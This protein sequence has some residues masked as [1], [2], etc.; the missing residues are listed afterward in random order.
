M[1]ALGQIVQRTASITP[2]IGRKSRRLLT[3]YDKLIQNVQ[4]RRSNDFN[5]NLS[6]TEKILYGHG[7]D[8]NSHPY[9][10]TPTESS[11]FGSTTSK[12]DKAV[13]KFP[14]SCDN[15]LGTLSSAV[16]EKSVFPGGLLLA[17]DAYSHINGDFSMLS[18]RSN[19]SKATRPWIV[20]VRLTGNLSEWTT[21]RDISLKISDFLKTK[22]TNE[23]IV[24]E[25]HGPGTDSVSCADRAVL[26][27]MAA[28]CGA[29][30]LFPFTDL[31]Y[32]YLCATGRR[33]L[34]YAASVI[35]DVYLRPDPDAMYD[36]LIEL[37]LDHLDPYI[38]G[39]FSQDVVTP[40]CDFKHTAVDE[41]WPQQLSAVTINADSP[42]TL[43][44]VARIAK[45]GWRKG[46]R[47]K[48]P[49][50]I[51]VESRDMVNKHEK[52]LFEK[53]GASIVSSEGFPMRYSV[54]GDA[55]WI[56]I[57]TNSSDGLE[58]LRYKGNP[59][60]HAF[61]ASTE[62]REKRRVGMKLAAHA[63]AYAQIVTAMAF[64]GK[65]TFNPIRDRIVGRDGMPF[66][67]TPQA[68]KYF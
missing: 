35:A 11:S 24:L 59:N 7:L 44:R 14:L 67:F 66:Q 20:G 27:T 13:H 4:K 62:V 5:K 28:E 64:A 34:A 21:P 63:H 39:P 26:C 55:E 57:M 42:D 65:L 38:R 9:L 60:T 30:A 51:S 50:V 61:A 45:Q 48:A 23:P 32:N 53:V 3:E 6:L 33:P 12:R 15:A 18:V 58:K 10:I 1:T 68:S 16:L 49:L 22:K 56:S 37:Q 52:D 17:N 43:E 41:E 8:E 29:S 47:A 19:D 31:T 54:A 25:Y 46:L 2:S 36:D 40:L